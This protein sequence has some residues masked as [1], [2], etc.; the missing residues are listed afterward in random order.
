VKP[1]LHGQW[2]I[3]GARNEWDALF[4]FRAA[5]IPTMSPA[6]FGESRGRSLLVTEALDGCVKLSQ[7]VIDHRPALRKP[8]LD[9]RQLLCDVAHLARAMHRAG[10]HHQDFYL[11]HLLLPITGARCG[12]HVIDLGRARKRRVLGERWI[13]KDLAQLLYSAGGI[14]PRDA[15]RF[16][17]HYLG[18]PLRIEDRRLM[19]LILDKRD[20]ITRHDRKHAA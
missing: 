11:G 1:L 5:G 15:L 6:A 16:L 17:R 7:W 2:P 4:H 14:R 13:I 3:V 18:R 10:L 12:V 9:D 19:G 8:T 20:A